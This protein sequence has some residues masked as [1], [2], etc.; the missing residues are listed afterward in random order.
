MTRLLIGILNEK[1]SQ[2]KNFAKALGGMRGNFNGED[3]VIVAAHGHLYEYKDPSE[4]V[5]Q[6]LVKKY[7]DWDVSNLPWNWR[8]LDFSY[9][10]KKGSSSTLRQIKQT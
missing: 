2:A 5:K 1:P 9:R 8:D 7:H 6:D 3:Y 4:M 10:K